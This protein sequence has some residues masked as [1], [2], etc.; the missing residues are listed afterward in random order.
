MTATS[1]NNNTYVFDPESVAEMGRLMNQDR[2]VTHAMGGPLTG[3]DDTSSFR[4]VLDLACGPGGWVLDVAFA[5][6]D[7]DVCGVDIS[8]TMIRYANARAQSQQLTNASFGVMDITQ[9]LD[10]ADASF[11][12]VNARFLF[13]AFNRATWIPFL[14]ECTRILRPGG[15]LRL[16]EPLCPGETN[17]TA[18]NKLAGYLLEGMRR[19]GYGF[20]T[21]G[22]TFGM[23]PMLSHLLHAAGYQHL[24]HISSVQNYSAY[25]PTWGDFFRNNQTA[26]LQAQPLF[27][28]TGMA[29]Q[30]E[31]DHLYRQMQIEQQEPGFTAMAYMITLLGTRPA[32]SSSQ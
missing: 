23:G 17:S 6:P 29:S 25:M 26:Y 30:E 15:T 21:D 5:H 13:S 31:I 11:D 32:L 22:R 20:S 2:M 10:F 3:I 9:P 8:Q 19:A 12:L 14:A 7:V 4:Q 1:D 27:I 16:T 18:F 28:K 24:R